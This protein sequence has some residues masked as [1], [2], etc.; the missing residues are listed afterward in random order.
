[1]VGRLVDFD[2]DGQVSGVVQD[3]HGKDQADQAE[4]GL[5]VGCT[6]TVVQPTAVVIKAVY[7]AVALP[8]V[9]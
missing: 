1:M 6:H 8:T 4:E 2:K 9:L 7:T 3:G 5:V